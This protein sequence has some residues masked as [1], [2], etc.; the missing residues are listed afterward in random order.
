MK[1]ADRFVALARAD[2]GH[3]DPAWDRDNFVIRHDPLQA[4]GDYIE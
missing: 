4:E 3:P 2:V 1:L